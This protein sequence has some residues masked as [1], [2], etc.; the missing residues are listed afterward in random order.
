MAE[1]VKNQQAPQQQKK[2]TS[3]LMKF[4]IAII[5]IFVIIPLL[6]A[7]LVF[8]LFYDSKQANIHYRDD[9]KTQ[10]VFND[11]V[12]YSLNDT[13]S[14]ETMEVRVTQD[15][16]N[17]V[18]YN[19]MKEINLEDTPVH[20]FYVNIQKDRYLFVFEFDFDGWF[21][22]RAIFD[23]RLKVDS[24]MVSFRIANVRIGRVDGFNKPAQWLFGVLKLPD[25]NKILHDNGISMT[26]DLPNLAYYY[27]FDDLA[28]DLSKMIGTGSSEY[29]GLI[30]EM[31]TSSEFLEVS[32][33]MNKALEVD[34]DLYKM[35]PTPEF[36]NIPDYEMPEGY[37][38]EIMA[39]AISKTKSYLESET[40]TPEVSQEILNYYVQGYDHL[41]DEQKAKVD[42]FLAS[43]DPATDTYSYEVPTTQTIQ[44]IVANQLSGHAPGDSHIGVNLN[45]N[46]LDRAIS[47][48][49][50]IGGS[51]LFKAKDEEGE[52]TCNFI[53][54][55]RINTVVDSENN[56]MFLTLSVNFNGYTIGVTA[57]AN[58]EPTSGYGTVKFSID[59]LYLG[60]KP[61]SDEVRD[62][63]IQLLINAVNGAAVGESVSI[64]T[65]GDTTILTLNIKDYLE[66]YGF[67]EADGYT[68]TFALEPQTATSPGTFRF[69]VDKD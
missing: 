19:A 27:K 4:F 56:A 54:V 25:F 50:S 9:Y 2:K 68:S 52:Y 37:L 57:K 40:I 20:N 15:A 16:L 35:K 65:V 58:L 64:E 61:L 22:T 63:F 44:Y 41:S 14:N 43:I 62:Q 47:E 5:I 11:I 34:I 13:V 29:V 55:D 45:T 38:T 28:E 59:N 42:P 3:G 48:A 1:A 53:T 39:N 21:K 66:A 67:F 46:Q 32:P 33:Y 49:D 36:Y 24:E 10:E 6:L 31:I 8:A 69:M 18:F 12:A 30:K 60:D 7:G 17:Q 23:A 51:I 26:L